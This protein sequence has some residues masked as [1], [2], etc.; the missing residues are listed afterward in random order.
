MVKDKCPVLVIGYNREVEI[1]MILSRIIESGADKI[2]VSLDG[3][4]STNQESKESC[5]KTRK[6]VE[7]YA[8]KYGDRFQLSFEKHNMGSAVN[9]IRSLDWFFSREDF[10]L[11]LEDDC[12]PDYSIFDYIIDFKHYLEESS[13]W[14]LSGYRPKIHSLDSISYSLVS[15]PLNWGWATTSKN[16]Q[17]MKYYL[18]APPTSSI[19]DCFV[20]GPRYIF[21]GV[22]SRRANKGWV[23]AWDIPLANAM[24][25]QD[26]SALM[27]PINL[28]SNIGTGLRA[29]NTKEKSPFFHSSTSKWSKHNF[30]DPNINDMKSELNQVTR[31]LEKEFISIK[32][33]HRFSTLISFLIDLIKPPKG[34]GELKERLLKI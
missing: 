19:F 31:I 17:K 26:G 6:I 3:P 9:V 27:P 21:W 14:L 16:W 18:L 22:G 20:K 34:R 2:Y 25:E 23:D 10:G 13:I 28:V 11:I 12:L 7:S 30:P 29:S 15:I 8:R 32:F 33:Y 5:K 4:V 1:D 24:L